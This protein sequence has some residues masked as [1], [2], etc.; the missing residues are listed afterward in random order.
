MGHFL[1]MLEGAY[2]LV[3]HFSFVR[4]NLGLRNPPSLHNSYYGSVQIIN[5]FFFMNKVHENMS[6]E[7]MY[8]RHF[9]TK[10]T[11]CWWTP[12]TRAF[13][14]RD[15]LLSV[16]FMATI[17]NACLIASFVDVQG[18]FTSPRVDMRS[19]IISLWA[20]TSLEF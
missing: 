11:L 17:N 15:M 19:L 10:E 18:F 2:L 5:F 7:F 13:Y 20:I 9:T 8:L 16:E 3:C 12:K 1:I 6:I 4:I 14:L